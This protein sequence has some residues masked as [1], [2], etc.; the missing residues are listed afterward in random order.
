MQMLAQTPALPLRRAMRVA[1]AAAA[2]VPAVR[3]TLLLHRRWAPPLLLLPKARVARA[4]A[5]KIA[6]RATADYD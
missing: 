2:V 1:E 6:G 4:F 3:L 5:G